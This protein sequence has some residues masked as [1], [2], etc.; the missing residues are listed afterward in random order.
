MSIQV[1]F[2]LYLD[3]TWFQWV[4]EW[5]TCQQP[6]TSIGQ[7]KFV[8]PQFGSVSIEI[9]GSDNNLD[10]DGKQQRFDE[11]LSN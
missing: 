7:I 11:I 9:D 3:S 5:K 6:I 10:F 2:R 1:G 4:V 8:V